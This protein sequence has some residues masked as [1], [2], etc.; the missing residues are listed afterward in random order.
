M[1][2]HGG[3]ILLAVHL[4]RHRDLAGDAHGGRPA[5]EGGA[6]IIATVRNW[7][8]PGALYG[9]IANIG[10]TS[11]M[12]DMSWTAWPLSL[13]ATVLLVSWFV[14]SADSGTL[15]ITTMLSMG[16]ENPPNKFRV[17]WGAGIG[18]TAI[19]LLMSAG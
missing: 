11:W 10:Q 3:G 9:T 13:L 14:T 4:R 18:A 6:G 2:A 16:D 15:V 17:I 8:L 1:R 5:A 7:E 12:G 19:A